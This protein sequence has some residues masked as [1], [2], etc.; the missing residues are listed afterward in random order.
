M[1]FYLV[2]WTIQVVIWIQ[3][4]SDVERR[5]DNFIRR[6][7]VKYEGVYDNVRNVM[8]N[9]TRYVRKWKAHKSHEKHINPIK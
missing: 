5:I 4:V 1:S 9:E 6:E 7:L 8:L 2:N 3:H